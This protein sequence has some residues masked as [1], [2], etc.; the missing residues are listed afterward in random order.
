[1]FTL[2]PDALAR[3]WARVDKDTGPIHPTLGR[4]WIWT[5]YTKNGYGALS[6][7]NRMEY[8]HRLSYLLHVGEIPDGIQVCHH[9]DNHPCVRPDH[10]FL[11]TYAENV[12]DMRAKGRGSP[13][14][15][16]Y[17]EEHHMVTLSD[18]Q[19]AEL[20][21]LRASRALSQRAVARKFGVSQSTVWRL[22]HGLYRKAAQ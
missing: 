19:V 12:A 5:G 10:F 20:R 1:M 7:N 16:S 11:G 4:C 3:F 13:P 18:E 9:C 14:P 17:G 6:V 22:A 15:H 2:S 21:H 8:T